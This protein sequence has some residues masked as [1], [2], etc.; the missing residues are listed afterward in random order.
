MERESRGRS[1]TRKN[2][3]KEVEKA[4]REA[5][6]AVVLPPYVPPTPEELARRKEAGRRMDAFREALG[7]VPFKVSDLIREGRD[8]EL[9]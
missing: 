5:L 2:E 3:L 4:A 7:T 6:K 9:E 1:A 8:E